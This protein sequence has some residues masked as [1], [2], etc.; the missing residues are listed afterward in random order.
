MK[1]RRGDLQKTGRSNQTEFS[2]PSLNAAGRQYDRGIV[3]LMYQSIVS[4]DDPGWSGVLQEIWHDVYHFPHYA[5]LC[6]EME[7]GNARAFL[8]KSGGAR[9]LLPF[10]T[11]PVPS[12]LTSD[13]TMYDV[14]APYGYP[15]PLVS[16]A[17]GTDNAEKDQFLGDA[18]AAFV[19]GL[20]AE[21]I[22]AGFFRLHPLFP[23][24]YTALERFGS[25]TQSGQTVAIDLSLSD[26]R[27][28]RQ[29]RANHRRDVAKAI[30]RGI[31]AEVDGTWT[32]LPA[33]KQAYKET[34]ARVNAHS[35]Y[36]FTDEYYVQLRDA[37]G[38]DHVHLWI[39]RR[40]SDV[41]AGALLTECAGI[42]QYHLGGTLNCFLSDAPLK[43]LFH[44]AIKWARARGNRWFHLGGGVGSAND[45]LLHF[46]LG[47]S[48]CLIN[49][50]TWRLVVDVDRYSDLLIK[51]GWTLDSA[52]R[53]PFFPAYRRPA[54]SSVPASA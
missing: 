47:F 22:V 40:A 50:H 32:H 21:G 28:W 30:D 13:K 25:V 43:L 44:T 33:F 38:V 3:L 48:P 36:R 6:A 42:V 51:A 19:D 1:F 23:L 34:M 37:L 24:D 4:P 17:T 5:R 8:A 9:L 54:S 12:I 53:S 16:Y 52:A 45:S 10:I 46:K 26:D 11:R 31:V 39:V 49:F 2:S 15:G 20:R 18:L 29:M 27:I 35:Y 41:M 7:G 14:A